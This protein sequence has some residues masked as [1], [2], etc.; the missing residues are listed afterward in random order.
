MINDK[1]RKKNIFGSKKNLECKTKNSFQLIVLPCT[2]YT[3]QV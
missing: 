1:N 3:V 2:S